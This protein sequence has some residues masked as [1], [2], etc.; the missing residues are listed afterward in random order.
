MLGV[1]RRNNS[2]VLG[3]TPC[4]PQ[5]PDQISL[6]KWRREG[7]EKARDERQMRERENRERDKIERERE[8]ERGGT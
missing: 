3:M 7:H 2:G 6:S 8:R 4:T 1:N 5:A